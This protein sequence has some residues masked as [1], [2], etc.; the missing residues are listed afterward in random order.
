MVALVFA[1]LG[2]MLLA[3]QAALIEP[4]Q[5]DRRASAAADVFAANFWAYEQATGTYAA[6]H[7][8]ASGTIGDASLTFA[9]GYI[10]NPAWTN[11]VSGG[12]LYTY[13]TLAL[14]PR[15][16]DAIARRGGRSLMIGIAQPG[17]TMTSFTGGAAGF[18]LPASIPVGALVVIGD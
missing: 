7:P 11:V 16:K 4:A 5:L 8:A 6:T 18:A 1:M 2:A 12:T 10:R 17:G 14:S 15:T 3:W 13:S 9:P